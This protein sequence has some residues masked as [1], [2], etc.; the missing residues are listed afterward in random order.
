MA[1]KRFGRMQPAVKIRLHS[2][3][4]AS[5]LAALL[6]PHIFPICSVVAPCQPGPPARQPRWGGRPGPPARQPRWGGRPGA[7]PPSVHNELR[8]RDTGP[9]LRV[10]AEDNIP[11]STDRPGL[12]SAT[13]GV[14][15]WGALAALCLGVS[16][17]WIS[18]SVFAT[19]VPLWWPAAGDA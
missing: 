18:P 5:R 19:F 14:R 1:P 3:G 13:S 2:A 6:L 10:G 9:I 16:V 12:D 11:W 17:A 7:S 8:R 15:D 4:P